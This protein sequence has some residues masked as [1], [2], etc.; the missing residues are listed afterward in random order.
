MDDK[1]IGIAW[2]RELQWPLLKQL[3]D[4]P[5]I[6]E[7]TYAEWL[8]VAEE[9]LATLENEGLTVV[10]IDIDLPE[11]VEWCKQQNQPNDSGARASFVSQKLQEKF[12]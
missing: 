8:K 6:I 5:E 2:Y 1:V 4:D 11:L 10:K 3:A 7:D 12:G 9:S